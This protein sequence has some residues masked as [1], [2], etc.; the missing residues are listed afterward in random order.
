MVWVQ[1]PTGLGGGNKAAREKNQHP[2]SWEIQD[3]DNYSK[4]KSGEKE[5]YNRGKDLKCFMV[6]SRH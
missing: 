3:P 4:K 1:R 2:I 6:M 5:V